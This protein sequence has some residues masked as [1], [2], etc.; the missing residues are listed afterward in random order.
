MP[1]VFTHAVLWFEYALVI[2][3]VVLL[4][5][6]VV[7]PKARTSAGPSPLPAWDAHPTEFVLLLAIVMFCS[8]VAAVSATTIVRLAHV[9]GD[10]AMLLAGAA[11]QFGMLVGTGVFALRCPSYRAH[12]AANGRSILMSGMA[13][14]IISMPILQGTSLAWN[15]LL[16]LFGIPAERQ[17]LI[18]MF[19]EAKSPGLLVSLIVLAIFIAPFAEEMVFRA[20]V[21]RFAR[22]RAP[23]LLALLIP[24]VLFASLHVNW[25]TLEGISSFAPLVVF[26][27]IFSLAYERTG[28]IGTTIVAHALFNL[29]TIVQI[30]SGVSS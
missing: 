25:S 15:R 29:N 10:A 11:G 24:A 18:R 28:H 30:F 5:V 19:T 12:A 3:G 14:F 26:A 7:S 1:P 21:F 17:D 27:V 2:T 22:T 6:Y 9:S 23:R 8:F 13:T 20:G 16:Q 4:W